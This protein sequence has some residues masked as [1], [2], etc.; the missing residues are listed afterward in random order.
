MAQEYVTDAGT[1]II[2]GAYARWQVQADDFGL[3]TTGILM[4]IGEANAGPDYSMESN[5]QANMFGPDEMA[6][7]V[8]KYKSGHLVDAFYAAINASNDPAIPGAP[9]GVILVKTNQSTKAEG[10]LAVDPFDPGSPYG[11]LYDRSYGSLGNLIAYEVEEESA[12]VFSHTFLWNDVVV[13]GGEEIEVNVAVNGVMH[14]ETFGDPMA[15]VTVTPA[16]ITA[17]LDGLAGLSASVDGDDYVTITSSIDPIPGAGKSFEFIDWTAAWTEDGLFSGIT[18][19]QVVSASEQ[20]INLKVSRA[21]D[22]ITEEHIAGGE[23][24]MLIGYEG[25]AATVTI[26]DTHLE[27][28]TGLNLL[29]SNFVTIADLTQYISAQAGYTARPRTAALGQRS[30]RELD[31]VVAVGIETS[32]SDFL[33]GRIKND[34]HAF[35]SSVNT[36]S[37]LVQLGDPAARVDVGLPIVQGL[38]YLAGGA[39]GATTMA[40]IVGAVAA[41]EKVR[42]NF[43]IPLF[44]RDA[45]AEGK[46]IPEGVT[47]AGSDYLIDSINAL[48]R[49]HVTAM[50]T[51]KRRRNRQAFLS[52]E[53]SV[54]VGDGGTI[55]DQ[56]EAAGNLAS[57]RC[58]LSFQRPRLVGAA[59]LVSQFPTWMNAVIAA[60]TQAAGFYRPIVHKVANISGIVHDSFDPES[61]SAMERALQAGLLPMKQREDGSYFWVSDQTTYSRDANFVFNSIQAVYVADIIALTTVQKMERAFLGKSVA[62]LSASLAKTFLETSVLDPMRA[63]RLISPSDDAPKGYKNIKVRINGPVMLVSFEVKLAG[64]LYF[65]PINIMISAVQQAA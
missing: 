10:P 62:E 36:G 52:R 7:V 55:D 38:Q 30:P 61:D 23:I 35:A 6:S 32:T 12:E 1:L 29:L 25:G 15:P 16:I 19:L 2:P 43:V 8:A 34:A 39:K 47:E 60:G 26:T 40:D 48:V 57:F 53:P 13:P 31:R 56:E 42:G 5:L 64:A 51:L 18:N 11:T 65:I 44:S 63:L 33:P 49:N 22:Q 20:S 54:A 46:D 50:S 3:A 9:T 37:Q 17:W 58:S 14:S 41:L 28:S 21:A 24:L 4:L 59:G 27:T 45:G